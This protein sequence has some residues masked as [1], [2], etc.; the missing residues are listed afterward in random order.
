[1]TIRFYRIAPSAWRLMQRAV[2]FYRFEACSCCTPRP[3]WGVALGFVGM[4]VTKG[5]RI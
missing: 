3:G 4:L 2:G 1:M 5:E